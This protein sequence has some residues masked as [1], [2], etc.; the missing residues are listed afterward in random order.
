M[1]AA[2]EGTGPMF[3]V[4]GLL[5]RVRKSGTGYS[6]SC[7]CPRHKHNDNNPSLSISLG[8]DGRVLLKCHAGCGTTDILAAL[9]M[10]WGDLFEQTSNGNPVR[11]FR[12]INQTGQVVAEHVREDISGDKI[13]RW[14]S[15]GKNGLNGTRTEDLPLYRLPD[16]LAADSTRP[17]I[18]CEGEKA[19]EALADIGLLAVGTVT[20]AAGTPSDIVLAPLQNREVWLWP[21]NDAAGKTHMANIAA[22]IR[23]SPKWIAW[24]DAPDKGDAADYVAAGGTAEGVAGL[25]REVTATLAKRTNEWTGAELSEARFD[26]PR[27]AIPG[28]LP[29]GLTILAGRPKLGKSWLALGWALDIAR[30]APIL[31]KIQSTLGDTLYLALE[32]GPRRMQERI[33]L[34]LGDA[35]WPSGITVITEWPR[36]DDGGLVELEQRLMANPN[37]RMVVIDTFKRVRPIE[38]GVQRLYD[39]DYDAIAPLAA[40]ARRHNV[41]L[42]VVFHTRKGASDDPLEMVSGTLGLSGAADSVI[43]LRRERGQADASLFITGRD[44]EEQDLALKWEKEDVLAWTLLGNAEQFRVTQ[45][46]QAIL[47][48]VDTLPGL[49]PAEIADALAKPR[50]AVRRLLFNMVR[51]GEIR[52]RDSRYYTIGNSGNTPNTG[53]IPSQKVLPQAPKTVTAGEHPYG[54]PNRT[55]PL[56]S[57]I[58]TP[59]TAVTTG[60]SVTAGT[61]VRSG[62]ALCFECGVRQLLPHETSGMCSVCSN[63]DKPF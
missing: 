29:S 59:V 42:V 62:T 60:T 19:A 2:H 24:K 34:M 45:E 35:A 36:L 28:V 57:T 47:D 3:R 33:A 5:E 23:P 14:E 16:L 27:W 11:R 41:A 54:S 7:P 9:K 39:L 1:T 37:L 63:R 52:V 26:P 25:L 40:L 6:A 30:G 48:T 46:R 8:Y 31:G 21:D 12:L 53:L 10:T 56:D 15:N 18:V 43:V 44:V 4:L 17:V 58:G 55:L 61:A 38:K 13:I 22:R 32:D 51:D 49:R 50:G 20:G